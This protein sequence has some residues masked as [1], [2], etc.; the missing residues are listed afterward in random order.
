MQFAEKLAEIQKARQTDLALCLSPSVSRMPLPMQRYDDP[1][2]PFSRAIIPATRDLV[3][4]YVF[5]T[6][7]YLTLGAAGA[8]ALE[9]TIALVTGEALAVLHGPFSGPDYAE[10]AAAFGADG[11]TLVEERS[12]AAY[13]KLGAFVVRDGIPKVEAGINVYWQKAGIFTLSDGLRIRMAS[14]DVLY[15]SHD[16][17]FAEQTRMVLEV[18]R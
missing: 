10:V 4:A 17:D 5:D 18:M 7:A 9:R 14:A 3:C 12:L 13:A 11:I 6:A 8:V 1:F 2:L 16:E 15:I